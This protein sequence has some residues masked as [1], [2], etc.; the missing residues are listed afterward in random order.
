MHIYTELDKIK[1]ANEYTT[2]LKNTFKLEKIPINNF[3]ISM[4]VIFHLYP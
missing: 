2:F 4:R 1:D 3:K